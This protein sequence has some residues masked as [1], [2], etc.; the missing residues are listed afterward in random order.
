MVTEFIND[1][2][3]YRAGFVFSRGIGLGFN[4]LP[5]GAVIRV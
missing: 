2:L 5:L 1:E 3:R 4:T